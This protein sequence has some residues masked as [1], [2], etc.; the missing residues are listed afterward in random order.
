MGLGLQAA[1]VGVVGQEVHQLVAEDGDA[2]GLEA[3]DGHALAQ[4][5]PQLGQDAPEQALGQAQHPVV[6]QGAP[7]AQ[8]AA[9]QQYPEAGRLQDTDGG[10]THVGVEVIGPGVDPQQH[11]RAAGVGDGSGA[12]A[13]PQ[14]PPGQAG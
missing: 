9:R 1:G 11:G 12:Q 13:G 4:L 14:G 3:H 8:R 6:V 7:A 5:R 2:A 10:F